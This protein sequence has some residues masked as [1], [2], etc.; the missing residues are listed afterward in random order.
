MATSTI[1]P[2]PTFLS[3]PLA[4]KPQLICAGRVTAIGDAYL[5]A[6]S[7]KY[8][9][10]KISLT[11]LGAGKDQNIYWL[12]RPEYFNAAM[13]RADLNTMAEA[14]K[15]VYRMYEQ[16]I[17]TNEE[18]KKSTLQGLTGTPEAF[19]ELASRLLS[20]GVDAI[21]ETPTLVSDV[22]RTFFVEENPQAVV[23]YVLG[24]QS[25]KTDEIDPETGKNVYVPSKWLEVK[26]YW[27]VDEEGKGLAAKA[28]LAE[29]NPKRYK[30]A[31][32]GE[33]F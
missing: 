3:P 16:H 17:C 22:L 1:E 20:L 32:S 27:T 21:T 19:N 31:Y 12:F 18:G 24:Q 15:G 4:Q 8:Y 28:R 23:G 25:E 30:L 9:V 14:D 10:V 33:S 13:T 29:K 11:A 5:S 2:R 26:S 6:K 7:E